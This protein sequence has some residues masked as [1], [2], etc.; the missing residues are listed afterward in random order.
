MKKAVS[1]KRGAKKDE[2]WRIGLKETVWWPDK[3]SNTFTAINWKWIEK[4]IF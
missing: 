3:G 4:F 1:I 2:I